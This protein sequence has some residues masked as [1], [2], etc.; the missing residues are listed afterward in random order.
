MRYA[1]V[2]DRIRARS[3]RDDS[4]GCLVYTGRT[5]DGYGQISLRGRDVRVHRVAFEIERGPIPAGL[6]PDHLCRNRACFNVEHMEL[7]TKRENILRG[8]GPPARNARKTHCIR[9]HLL[10]VIKGRP[11]RGCREC[12]RATKLRY[13][14]RNVARSKAYYRANA[15]RIK[16]RERARHRARR[17]ERI[18]A[19]PAAR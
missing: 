14:R 16:A 10:E 6:E 13:A 19:C 1:P 15:E 5:W 11:G 12:I 2:M 4:T 9:G 7:V 17:A 8:D 3:R 18:T